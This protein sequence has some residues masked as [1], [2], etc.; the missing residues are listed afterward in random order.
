MSNR[1]REDEIKERGGEGR[2]DK[3]KDREATRS[4]GRGLEE[5]ASRVLMRHGNSS[6]L[7]AATGSLCELRTEGQGHML[8]L[9][10]VGAL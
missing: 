2:E 9:F 3:N 1:K 7:P 8:A 4:E 10:F 5:S 6:P